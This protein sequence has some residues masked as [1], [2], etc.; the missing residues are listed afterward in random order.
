MAMAAAMDAKNKSKKKSGRA[1]FVSHTQA[2]VFLSK[3]ADA[4]EHSLHAHR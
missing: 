2:I 4:S 3:E 1:S